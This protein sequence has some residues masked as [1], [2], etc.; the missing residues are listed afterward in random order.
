MKLETGRL[1]GRRGQHADG[2]E[3]EAARG[4][5]RNL[6][7]AAASPTV[8][9]PDGEAGFLRRHDSAHTSLFLGIITE[10]FLNSRSV[11]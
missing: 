1:E 10:A 11:K 5:Q 4:A 8:V 9:H 7:V 2:V 3:A 6:T